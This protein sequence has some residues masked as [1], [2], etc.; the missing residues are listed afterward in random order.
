MWEFLTKVVETEGAEA[1]A[2]IGTGVMIRYLWLEN[3]ALRQELSTLQRQRVED[4]QAVVAEVV[5]H[6]EQTKH[7]MSNLQKAVEL[8]TDV[9]RRD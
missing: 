1:L 9:I 4:S 5:T 8:L 6:V 3:R 2:Y 7:G